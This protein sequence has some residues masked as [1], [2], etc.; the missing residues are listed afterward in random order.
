MN[1]TKF[2][3]M[4]GEATDTPLLRLGVRAALTGG[5]LAASFGVAHAQTAPA[6]AANNEPVLEEVVVTGSRIA[7]PNQ[8]SISPVT[9]VG[10][11]DV[12]KSGA[13]R[14][15]DLLNQLPQVFAAQGASAS[16]AADGTATVNL[17]GLGAKRTLVLVDGLRLGPGDPTSGAASDIN[18]IPAAMIDSIEILTGGA[19]SVYGAD[20]VG[21]VVNFKLNDHFEGVKLVADGGIYQNTN[22]NTQGVESAL[23]A[24]GP[25]YTPAPSSVWAGAQ[26]ELTFIA[27]L[28]SPDGNGNATV[29]AGY[30]NVLPAVQSKYSVSACTFGSGFV[31]GSSS[32][33]G[34]FY[35]SGSGTS[36]PPR[37]IDFNGYVGGVPGNTLDETVNSAG[38]LVPYTNADRYN[39][40]AL[41]YFQRSDERYTA[42]AF[43]H[44]EFNEH[45][46]VYSQF[47]FMDDQSIAQ[48][49]GSGTFQVAYTVPCSNPFLTASELSSWCGG[50]KLGNVGGGFGNF[51]IGKRNVEGGDRLSDLQHIDFHEVLGVKGKINDAWDY[52]ASWQF[53]TVDLTS[54]VENYFSKTN[55][56]NAFDVTGTAANPACAIGPPCVPYNIFSPGQVTQAALNYL[57][58]PG[59]TPGQIKQQVVDFNMT[60]DFGKY[61]VQLP[62][63]QSGLKVNFGVEYRD[64]TLD[65]EP[66]EEEISG[67]LAGNTPTVPV[68]GSI[69]SRE[70]FVEARMPIL[71]DMPGAK[72]LAFE[73]GYRYS[74]YSTGF[75]TNTYKFGVEYSPVQDIRLRGSFQ[76]AVRAPNII[77]LFAP[78]AITLDGTVDPCAGPA[79]GGLVN[80]Y[81]AAQCAKT[82]V[83]AGQFGKVL[84]N[85]AA[86]YNGLEGGNPNLLPETALTTS[87][88]IGFTPSFIPNFRMQI[89][90]FDIKIENVIE[91]IGSNQILTDCLSSSLF[92]NDVHRDPLDGSLWLS[93][94]GFVTDSLANVGTLETKGIDVDFEY[95]LDLGAFGK[96]HSSL[97]GTYLD[98]YEETPISAKGSTAYNCAGYYG[99]SCSNFLSGAGTPVFHWRH[100]LR[101]TWQTPWKGIDVTVSWRY[102]SPVKLEALSPNLNIGVPATQTIANGG[103]SNTDAYISSY[104]YIDLTASMKLADKISLRLGVNNVLDKQPP[105]IGTTNLPAPPI[106]NGNTMPQVYDS[107]G[108]YIFGSLQVQF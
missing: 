24:S 14:V 103:I 50:S 54:N 52:D 12:E 9:F 17:R 83:T 56:N 26:R 42:G 22:T 44:Y 43:L 104:S 27:G 67:D 66:D 94:N 18:M 87:F 77:E 46:T 1:K 31:A 2:V 76:R 71:D 90:Y 6:T 75:D 59:E 39:Y 41:N 107:L 34:K 88:G 40:G 25:N 95:A 85:S 20:A 21:G 96:L 102:F 47:M 49:A 33:G 15:E 63:A 29:Y 10:A 68:S 62:T 60:G 48:I 74:S 73:T 16:N 106:G 97:V 45:A 53:S 99:A 58:A 64:V 51:I 93:N 72:S 78:Q 100:T 30:R 36:S 65:F 70:G 38:V 101:E 35:C 19:S 86:Q 5:S 81:S 108:R 84:A 4:L 98:E 57:Y 55:L 7:A 61:G 89:D 13:T 105:V 11:A 37:F 28:N 69:T 80:G 82:G 23:I 91:T 8:V 79:V 3:K 92:C 32:T